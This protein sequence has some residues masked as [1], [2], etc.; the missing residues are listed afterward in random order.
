MQEQLE[1]EKKKKKKEFGEDY[2]I[3][4]FADIL[5][6]LKQHPEWLEE[7]RKLVL[8]SEL[9]ELPKKIDE[10]IKRVEK[11]EKNQ[12]EFKKDLETL[13]QDVAILKQDVAVLKQDVNYLKGEFG[14]FKGK[15]FERTVRERYYA[16]FGRLLKKAKLL[17]MPALVE[18]IDEAEERGEISSEERESLFELDLVVCGKIRSTGKEVVLAVEVSYSLYPEDLERAKKRAQVLAKVLKQEVIPAVVYVEAKEK[19]LEGE[20]VLL[21][22]VKY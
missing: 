16:Y 21:I 4:T 12:E 17:D 18:Q 11:L 19:V 22:H 14:R 5:R 1:T 3:L 10:L 7:L 20:E 2:P 6:A 13:K 15:E 8:T 9:L